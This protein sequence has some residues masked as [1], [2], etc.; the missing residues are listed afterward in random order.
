MMLDN[1]LSGEYLPA[2]A[3]LCATIWA[4]NFRMWLSR[5]CDEL[6]GIRVELIRKNR[7]VQR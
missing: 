5:I 4:M 3:L 1:F 6:H 7:E 2:I